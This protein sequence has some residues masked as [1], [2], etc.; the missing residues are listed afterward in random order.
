MKVLA[1]FAHPDDETLFAGGMLALL[2]NLRVEVHLICATRGEGGECGEPALCK[3]SQLGQV[4]ESELRF[5]AEKLGVASVGFLG[6]IDPL[7][8]E[9]NRLFAYTNDFKGLVHRL[10]DR[11]REENPEVVISH[12]SSGEYGHPGHLLTHRAVRAALNQIHD[13]RILY[14]TVQADFSGH[15]K[16]RHANTSDPADLVLDV[17]STLAQKIAAAECH[18][19]QGALIVRRKSKELGRSTSIAEALVAIEPYHRVHPS[20]HGKPQDELA[21]LLRSQGNLVQDGRHV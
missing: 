4:R 3:Q 15:P 12:G 17:N 1:I 8:G 18:R 21:S 16:P 9:G 7:V 6:Y 10:V 5:A 20:C 19:T 13:Q 14:Y 2:T 11:I